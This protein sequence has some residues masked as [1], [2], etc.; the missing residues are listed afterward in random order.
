LISAIKRIDLG[1]ELLAVE[2]QE[3]R[4]VGDWPPAGP[5]LLS[6]RSRLRGHTGRISL[7]EHIERIEQNETGKGLSVHMRRGNLIAFA[8]A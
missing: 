2:R 8:I 5:P 4:V 1:A 6:G 3:R 7:S